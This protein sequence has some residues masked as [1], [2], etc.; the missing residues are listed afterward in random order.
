MI[1]PEAPVTF[2]VDEVPFPALTLAPGDA[3]IRLEPYSVI[4]RHRHVKQQFK[5]ISQ[6]AA[7]GDTSSSRKPTRG[8]PV[9]AHGA[10][11]VGNGAHHPILGEGVSHVENDSN[12][13]VPA[14]VSGQAPVQQQPASQRHPGV[15][16]NIGS[17]EVHMQAQQ[18]V[19]PDKVGPVS[20]GNPVSSGNESCTLH[21]ERHEHMIRGLK[22]KTVWYSTRG[23]Q[24][25]TV[26]VPIPSS[27][28]R[29]GDL[30]V[31]VATGNRKQVWLWDAHRWL[32][33]ELHHPHPY[34]RE[35]VLNILAN[36]EPS[37]VTKDTIRTYIGRLKKRERERKGKPV[38]AE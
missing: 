16:I 14:T 10:A 19:S 31:H 28:L 1:E 24:L 17:A 38:A 36:G 22:D 18:P 34:L 3:N 29:N 27:R 5:V 37:W 2:H 35:Y 6:P 30:F 25:L 21:V 4:L 32:P 9:I 8:V 20:L 15:T 7:D 26:P 23:D 33:V 12:P 13:V 11:S